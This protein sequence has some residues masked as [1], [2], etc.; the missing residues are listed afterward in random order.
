MK[1]SKIYRRAALEVEKSGP[2]WIYGQSQV[3]DHQGACWGILEAC[4]ALSCQDLEAEALS[5]FART[6]KPR[7]R[8]DADYWF[9]AVIGAPTEVLLRNREY[10]VL[11]LL[12]M[13]EIMEGEEA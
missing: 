6:F 11:A 12:L 7:H 8:F 9:G 5:R 3:G 13:A 1:L 2:N 4:W 10:R